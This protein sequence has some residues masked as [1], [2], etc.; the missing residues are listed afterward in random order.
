MSGGTGFGPDEYPTAPRSGRAGPPPLYRV[1]IACGI[2][3]VL[4]AIGAALV[5]FGTDRHPTLPGVPSLPSIPTDGTGIPSIPN[6]PSL[7]S[8][9]GLP[10]L[11]A[12][13]SRPAPPSIPGPTS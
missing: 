12:F 3:G 5:D 10:S 13:P 6:L 11:P 9:P 2:V 4:I 1:M 8:I 7:P